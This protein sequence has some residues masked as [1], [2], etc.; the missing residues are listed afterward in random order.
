MTGEAE[1]LRDEGY[2]LY[3]ALLAEA[4]LEEDPS[5]DADEVCRLAALNAAKHG[6]YSGQY[7]SQTKETTAMIAKLIRTKGP[8]G[9]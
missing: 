7:V 2:V 8:G 5:R 6:E 1:P 9:L 3:T 4:S